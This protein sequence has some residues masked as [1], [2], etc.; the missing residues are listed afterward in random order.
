MTSWTIF[1]ILAAQMRSLRSSD[2]TLDSRAAAGRPR[3]FRPIWVSHIGHACLR[4]AL[5]R[6]LFPNTATRSASAWSSPAST[7]TL[8][9]LRLV[10]CVPLS[11]RGDICGI[12]GSFRCS[13]APCLERRGSASVGHLVR[14]LA[15]LTSATLSR[16]PGSAPSHRLEAQCA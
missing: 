3:R 16:P 9:S 14:I 13:Q 12:A 10:Q 1:V 7:D 4:V 5:R 15:R 11:I 2:A 6:T 8:G